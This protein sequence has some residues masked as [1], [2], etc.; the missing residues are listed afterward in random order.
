MTSLTAGLLRMGPSHGEGQPCCRAPSQHR[1][2]HVEEVSL[3]EELLLYT[4]KAPPL[5]AADGGLRKG[6]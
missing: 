1:Y 2:H 5:I 6:P 4:E 3:A